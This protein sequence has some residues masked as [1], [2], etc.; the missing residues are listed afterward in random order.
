MSPDAPF[1]ERSASHDQIDNSQSRENR[2]PE[3][4]EHGNTGQSGLAWG[5]TIPQSSGTLAGS[6]RQRFRDKISMHVRKTRR[7]T[8]HRLGISIEVFP[9]AK[10]ASLNSRLGTEIG[11]RTSIR[12]NSNLTASAA[13]TVSSRNQNPNAPSFRGGYSIPT[14]VAESSQAPSTGHPDRLIGHSPI[15]QDKKERIRARRREA[16]LK[17]KAEMMA[18]CEC[19]SECQCRG[20]SVLSNAASYGQGDSDRSIQVPEHV[21]QH[22]L[23]E[24]SGSWTSHSS[25]SMARGSNLTGIDG[26]VHFDL[27]NASSDDPEN[28]M[29]E[30][31]SSFDD[32]LS[33]ASTACIRSNGSSIS[34]VSR[35]PSSLTR[36]NTAPGFPTRH[37]AHALRPSVLE[38]L[39][40]PYIPDQVYSTATEVQDSPNNRGRDAGDT[41]EQALD[42]GEESPDDPGRLE[43]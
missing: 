29:L 13:D 17:R 21:L 20:G 9:T 31:R 25:S 10:P 36:S 5:A 41:S 19:R 23:N 27:R 37:N 26:H 3:T 18:T 35:R 28:L 22:I 1:S 2:S 11:Q 7:F 24:S 30:T 8:I 4:A 38:A 33:Q 43:G 6:Q 39:Q 12:G 16:T 40:N 14:S 15:Q 42:V 34:L 32:R